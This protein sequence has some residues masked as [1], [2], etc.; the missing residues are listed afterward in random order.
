ME[1][2]TEIRVVDEGVGISAE[3]HR[4]LY[5]PFYRVREGE[6]VK[7]S[8]RIPSSGL[9]LTIVKH[10]VEIHEGSISFESQEGV[11]TTFIIRLPIRQ[12]ETDVSSYGEQ[13]I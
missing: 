4:H 12:I 13:P 5:E 7:F 3:H 2:V 6:H 9:G 1:D 11:G 8:E 10:A